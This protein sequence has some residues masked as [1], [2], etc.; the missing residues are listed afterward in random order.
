MF[1]CRSIIHTTIRILV[2]LCTTSQNFVVEFI[3][4]PLKYTSIFVRLVPRSGKGYYLQ[5]LAQNI[6]GKNTQA[7]LIKTFARIHRAK[8]FTDR[9]NVAKRISNKKLC[10]NF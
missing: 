1:L 9:Q 3:N 5:L 7:K 4:L 10:T 6:I 2:L 8:I